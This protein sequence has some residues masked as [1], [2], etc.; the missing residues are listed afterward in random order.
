MNKSK[1]KPKKVLLINTFRENIE[2]KNKM[3][4]KKITTLLKETKK[5]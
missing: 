4:E 3:D 1:K 5:I 2:R